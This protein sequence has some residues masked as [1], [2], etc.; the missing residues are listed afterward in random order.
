MIE[1]CS[2]EDNGALSW[3]AADAYVSNL[4]DFL[5]S[6]VAP[7]SYWHLQFGRCWLYALWLFDKAVAEC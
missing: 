4:K 7:Q 3:N 5:F 1:E 6:F 2:D